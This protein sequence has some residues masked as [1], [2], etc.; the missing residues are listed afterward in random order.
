MYKQT[1]VVFSLAIPLPNKQ[2]P[3]APDV[4]SSQLIIMVLNF[5]WSARNSTNFL[6]LCGM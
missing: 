3:Q 1:F 5:N 2:L 6:S 4:D